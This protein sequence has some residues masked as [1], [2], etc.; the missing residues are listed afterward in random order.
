MEGVGAHAVADDFTENLRAACLGE[1]QLFQDEDARAFADH[2]AV[3]ILVQGAAGVVG[4]IVAGG[5]GLHGGESAHTQRGDGG[6]CTTRDH[7]VGIAALDDAISVANG[8]C[9]GGAGRGRCLIRALG[10]VADRDMAGSQVHDRCGNEERR[11]LAR[12]TGHQAG[13]L[14]LDKSKPPMPEPMWTPTPR[15]RG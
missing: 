5:E 4:I 9:G 10:A 11:D 14:A 3:A 13:V 2:K 12:A 15:F 8:V 1:L 6:F 7:G